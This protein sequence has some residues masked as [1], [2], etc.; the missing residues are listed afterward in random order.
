MTTRISAAALLVAAALTNTLGASSASA[1]TSSVATL[2]I[3]AG[4]LQT[5]LQMLAKQADIQLVYVPDAAA[6]TRTAPLKG[7]YTA[8]QALQY[9]LANTDLTYA[10]NDKDTVVIKKREIKLSAAGSASA[11]T[12]EGAEPPEPVVGGVDEVIVSAQKQGDERLQDVPVPVTAIGAD[13]LVQGNLLRLRDYY[14]SVPGLTLVPNRSSPILAI[15]GLI[16][17]GEGTG[18]VS[19]PTVGVVFDDIPYGS[20]TAIGGG[21]WVP[22][23]DPNDLARVEV[24]RGP[25]GT[26]YGASSMGGLLK[27]VTLA[28][29]TDRFSGRVQSGF[30][31]VKNGDDMGYQ[32]RGS[33]NVPLTDTMAIR[34]S[35]F[36][37]N[38]PGYIHDARRDEDA[39]NSVGVR[40]GRLAGLWRISPDATLNLS[41]VI[42]REKADA[43]SY[44]HLRADLGEL[45]QD[46]QPGAGA[47]DKEIVMYAAN[48]NAS[49]FG[50]DIASNTGYGESRFSFI[51]DVGGGQIFPGGY[52]TDKFSQELRLTKSLGERARLLV[53]GFYTHENSEVTGGIQFADPVSGAV[54]GVQY[55]L[56]TPTVFEEKPAFA[57]LTLQLTD[58]FDVQFGGRKTWIRQTFQTTVVPQP[59]GAGIG[60]VPYKQIDT[61]AFTY[62]ITPRLKISPELMVYL[63]FASGYRAGGVNNNFLTAGIPAAYEPDTTRNYEAGV[64]GTFFDDRLS[65]DMSVYSIDWRDMQLRIFN[66]PLNYLANATRAE[67]R[68]VDLSVELRPMNGLKLSGWV[69]YNDAALAEDL[70]A[71]PAYGLDG[72]Q[73][74][75]SSLW[76]GQFKLDRT[77]QINDRLLGSFGGSVNYVDE[78]KSN[79]TQTA[80]Q[81]RQIYPGYVRADLRAGLEY[82]SWTYSLFVNNLLDKRGVDS[83]NPAVIPGRVTYIQPRTAGVSI[84]RSF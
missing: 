43:P 33:V 18:G 17:A 69:A 64:K 7:E 11:A 10:T 61:D 15:R 34:A 54:T 44:S 12:E 59:N 48:L 58:A 42:Q 22:D 35:A 24:L 28:P 77:F 60:N 26:L 50:F 47:Y 37:R 21:T 49:A 74:P 82:E 57:N 40:G 46:R 13:T 5:A 29:S 6:G 71:G 75:Y 83:G 36:T 2:D 4:T 31:S 39:I 62:L 9:F 78:R 79:F 66:P 25:Q 63:R 73:L 52:T 41:A 80:L 8:G 3:P 30:S 14:T 84:V 16:S 32:L 56:A 20:S 67:S 51:D 72:D 65:V 27:F 70:P 53:G 81:Q 76:S 38:D 55:A 45:E 1:D 23:M 68:G 19:N